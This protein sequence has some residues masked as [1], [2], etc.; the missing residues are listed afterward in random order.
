[1][2]FIY[3]DRT[4]GLENTKNW[5][6][7]YDNQKRKSRRK[8]ISMLQGDWGGKCNIIPNPAGSIKMFNHMMG[9]D[10]AEGEATSADGSVGEVGS[11]SAGMGESFTKRRW[12]Y[13][14]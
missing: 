8:G 13:R 10:S 14:G 3:E 9:A 5:K 1:M 4:P 2:K 12:M 6:S 11:A 7:I